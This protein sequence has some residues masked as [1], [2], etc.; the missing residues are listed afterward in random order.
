MMILPRQARD[1]HRESTQKQ[2]TVFSQDVPRQ[3]GDMPMHLPEAPE[4][5]E[6]WRPWDPFGPPHCDPPGS[7]HCQYPKGPPGPPAPPPAPLPVGKKWRCYDG[8]RVGPQG[9]SSL[10]L[11][12]ADNNNSIGKQ[13]CRRTIV[14][15]FSSFLLFP[16]LTVL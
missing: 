8:T 1:K 5:A 16:Y 3:Q 10:N 2:T 14:P 11:T 12:V 13:A 6:P 4:P 15:S 7:V 9:A